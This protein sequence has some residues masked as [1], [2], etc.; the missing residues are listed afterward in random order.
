MCRLTAITATDLPLGSKRQIFTQMMLR[1]N[2]EGQHDGWGV[3]DGT[4]IYKDAKDFYLSSLKWYNKLSE[5]DIFVGHVRAASTGTA[6]TAAESHPFSF[7]NDD[8]TNRLVGAHNGFIDDSYKGYEY[9]ASNPVSDSFRAFWRL[10]SVMAKGHSTVED[11]LLNKS[12]L[13][14]WMSVYGKTS[15]YAFMLFDRD[16]SRLHIFRNDQRALYM[17]QAGNGV[18][19]NTSPDVVNGVA[20]YAYQAFGIQTSHTILLDPN[21][22]YVFEVGKDLPTVAESMVLPKYESK[23]TYTAATSTTRYGYSTAIY[24]EDKWYPEKKVSES[25]KKN[26]TSSEEQHN[27]LEEKKEAAFDPKEDNRKKRAILDQLI[28]EMHPLRLPMVLLFLALYE[29]TRVNGELSINI[30]DMDLELMS[31]AL[32]SIKTEPLRADQANKITR[33]NESVNPV[34]EVEYHLRYVEEN[35][36]FFDLSDDVL[37]SVIEV[38]GG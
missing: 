9:K 23:T 10:C 22:Y 29:N 6:R 35:T 34:A 37:D 12:V 36:M 8:K 3:T 18:I 7:I 17:C 25:G 24:E 13:E 20:E 38:I 21:M 5:R 2:A 16:V 31:Y 15:A 28:K 11:M 33:W 14:E 32:Q 19:I 4:V 27:P 1:A 30:D 26:E